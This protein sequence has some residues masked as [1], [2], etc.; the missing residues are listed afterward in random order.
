MLFKDASEKAKEFK[1]RS[2]VFYLQE[3]NKVLTLYA[4]ELQ[5]MNSPVLK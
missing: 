3:V 5:K 2:V 4:R 1:F